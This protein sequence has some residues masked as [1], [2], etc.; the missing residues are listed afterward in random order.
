MSPAIY[1]LARQQLDEVA[2][3]I[4]GQHLSVPSLSSSPMSIWDVIDALAV[5]SAP[6]FRGLCVP[7]RFPRELAAESFQ[8]AIREIEAEVRRLD[9][10]GVALAA[11][12]DWQQRNLFPLGYYDDGIAGRLEWMVS[13]GSA[14]PGLEVHVEREDLSCCRCKP[15]Q[16]WPQKRSMVF[17]P[18]GPLCLRHALSGFGDRLRIGGAAVLASV[19][20]GGIGYFV[21]SFLWF[22]AGTWQVITDLIRDPWNSD[23][24]NSLCALGWSPEVRLRCKFGPLS[25]LDY[26][27]NQM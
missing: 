3:R 25:L 2:L 20:V 14:G 22:P 12:K 27:F 18:E 24:W 26:L 6:R 9:P 15:A 17:T 13:I 1:D 5:T 8:A 10:S 16:R 21:W 7:S 11:F 19:V 4:G 23:P